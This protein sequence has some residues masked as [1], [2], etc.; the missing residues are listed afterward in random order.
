[1]AGLPSRPEVSNQDRSRT[2][3][4]RAAT[5]GESPVGETVLTS[6]ADLEYR[7]TRVTGW[8]GWPTTVKG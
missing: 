8:E 5:A 2:P 6:V 7:P 4:E 1:V 3:L